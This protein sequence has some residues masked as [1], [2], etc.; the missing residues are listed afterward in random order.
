M[1]DWLVSTHCLFTNK[2]LGITTFFDSRHSTYRRC[3]WLLVSQYESNAT[4]LMFDD[5]CQ[6]GQG[7]PQAHVVG[8]NTPW[9]VL[10]FPPEHPEMESALADI[11]NGDGAT[12]FSIIC[13]IQHNAAILLNVTF[14]LLFCQMSLYWFSLCW[15][16]LRHGNRC[17]SFKAYPDG[18][19]SRMSREAPKPT[20]C[21]HE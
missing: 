13:D 20:F 15:V 11:S 16:S 17:R 12:T 6:E 5:Q 21:L 7:F 2:W 18:S 14:Y 4:N 19:C 3:E 9:R 8:E 10:V 1:L